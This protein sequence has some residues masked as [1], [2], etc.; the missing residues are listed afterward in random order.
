MTV[1]KNTDA[2]N[3]SFNGTAITTT[4]ATFTT[5]LAEKIMPNITQMKIVMMTHKEN[6]CFCNYY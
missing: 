4:A 2:I 6:I 3:S 1:H 5:M